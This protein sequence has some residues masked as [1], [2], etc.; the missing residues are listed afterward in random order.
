S[1]VRVTLAFERTAPVGS[2]TVPRT[3]PAS[4][5]ASADTESNKAAKKATKATPR[6][7]NRV[8]INMGP[9]NIVYVHD[10]CTYTISPFVLPLSRKKCVGSTKAGSDP[11]R[12][13]RR[14]DGLNVATS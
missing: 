6:G 2:V 13:Q 14:Q 1:F 7:V 3:A 4:T 11:S 5:W 9:P 12:V 10:S 8:R